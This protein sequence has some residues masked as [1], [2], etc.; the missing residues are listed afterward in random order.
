MRRDGALAVKPRRV[1]RGRGEDVMM[2]VWII[3]SPHVAVRGR[4]SGVGL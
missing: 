4:R 2:C 1:R 3:V